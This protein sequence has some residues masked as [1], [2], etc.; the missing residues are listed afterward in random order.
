MHAGLVN[1][2]VNQI[3]SI[4]TYVVG[5]MYPMYLYRSP[6][7]CSKE[8]RLDNLLQYSQSFEHCEQF[9][10]TIIQKNSFNNLI[11]VVKVLGKTPPWTWWWTRFCLSANLWASLSWVNGILIKVICYFLLT[12]CGRKFMI[13]HYPVN[14]D[15]C[16]QIISSALVDSKYGVEI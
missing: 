6:L 5:L 11:S 8:R 9:M 14:N 12:T 16:T 15:K 1:W 2:C 10:C 4:N 3:V 13:I 7:L